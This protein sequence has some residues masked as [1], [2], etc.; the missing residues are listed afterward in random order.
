MSETK[1]KTNGCASGACGCATKV[2]SKASG[3]E[4]KSSGTEA[5]VSS[6]SVDKKP[7]ATTPTKTVIQNGKGSAP[8]NMGPQF[9][10]NFTRIKWGE[11]KRQRREGYREVKVYG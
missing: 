8:R 4:A 5:K 9:K 7:K 6:D 2:E 11:E 3:T 1:S 10:K